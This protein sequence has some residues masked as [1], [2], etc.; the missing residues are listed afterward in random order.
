MNG[1]ENESREMGREEME[2]NGRVG[3]RRKSDIPV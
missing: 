2:R 1:M 3:S